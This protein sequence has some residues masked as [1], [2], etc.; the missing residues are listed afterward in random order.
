MGFQ[1]KGTYKLQSN[2]TKDEKGVTTI[3]LIYM[4]Y[5]LYNMESLYTHT[6]LADS[7]QI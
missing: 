1:L 2:L 7:K 4:F 3:L 5:I 6:S